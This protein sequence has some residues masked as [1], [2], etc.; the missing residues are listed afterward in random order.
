MHRAHDD[1]VSA[2]ID[3]LTSTSLLRLSAVIAVR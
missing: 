2:A 3:K 1:F